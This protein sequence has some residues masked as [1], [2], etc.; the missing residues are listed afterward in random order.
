MGGHRTPTIGGETHLP[1]WWIQSEIR[2]F[3]DVAISRQTVDLIVKAVDERIRE[4]IGLPF[5]F[6]FHGSHPSAM[7]QV[8]DATI[9]DEIDEQRLFATALSESWRDLC[10]GGQQH[11]DIYITN[12]AFLNDTVSWGAADFK[13]GAMVFC[14]YGNRSQ[15]QEFLRKVALHETNHLLGMYCHCDD[16]QNV[17]ELSYTPSCNMHYSCPSDDLCPKCVEFIRHWWAQIEYEYEQSYG[18]LQQ[19]M[20]LS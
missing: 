4:T 16:Y 7:E 15:S 20:G 18:E 19:K 5:R 14:L 10:H 17:E 3:W 11:A 2:V 12:K 6:K 13:F 9:N 8:V 1:H